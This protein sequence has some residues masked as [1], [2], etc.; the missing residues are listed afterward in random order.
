MR[1]LNPKEKLIINDEASCKCFL[2]SRSYQGILTWF[3]PKYYRVKNNCNFQNQWFPKLAL[4]SHQASLKTVSVSLIHL[5]W[6][7]F[8]GAHSGDLKCNCTGQVLTETIWI[9]CSWSWQI[10]GTEQPWQDVPSSMLPPYTVKQTP[11]TL[12]SAKSVWDLCLSVRGHRVSWL[13]KEMLFTIQAIAMSQ[14]CRCN[15]ISCFRKAGRAGRSFL[16]FTNR[17]IR[18]LDKMNGQEGFI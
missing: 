17:D 14:D 15:Q 8:S 9:M 5:G 11:W 4:S 12:S 1:W 10:W 7:S 3:H 13:R 2:L 6:K 16:F 18:Q